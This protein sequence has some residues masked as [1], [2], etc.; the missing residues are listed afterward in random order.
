MSQDQPITFVCLSSG[1]KGHDFMRQLKQLGARVFLIVDEE[2]ANED[3]PKD[4]FDEFFRMPDLSKQE[5]VL[6]G[7][8]YLARS[9][10]IDRIIALDDYDVG[11]AAHIR[12]HLRLPGMGSTTARYFRDKLSMRMGAKAAGIPVP[13]FSPI[14]NY[15]RLQNFLERVPPPWVVKPRFEAGAIGIKKVHSAGEAWQVINELGDQQSFYLIEQ[16]L[17]GDVYHVDS[18]FSER[19]MAFVV[20]HQYARPPLS[21]SHDGGIFVTRTLPREEEEATTLRDLNRQLLKGLGMVRGVNHTEYIRSH[22][23]G[24]FYF[25]ETAA[26]VGGAHIAET[27]EAATGLNLWREWA[28]LEIAHV[29]GERYQLPAVRQEYAGVMIC[30]A[31]QEWPDM[32]AYRD[33]EVVWRVDKKYHAGLIV[34]SP[35]PGRVQE[36]LNNYTQRF[37]QDFLAIGH[38]KEARRTA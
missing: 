15:E 25:L 14:F 9:N 12:E 1:Y 8:S 2:V 13:A 11:L 34:S 5:E 6:F 26:R 3:W 18:I 38:A 4:V 21:V 7:V 27:V 28:K 23:D 31:R 20:A 33:P 37:A 10:R 17:P 24:R 35:Y 29:L 16:F 36:L 30:L 32:S 22:A 19:E